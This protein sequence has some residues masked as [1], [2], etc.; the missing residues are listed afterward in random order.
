MANIKYK[1]K[2][3]KW[4]QLTVADLGF[5]GVEN[6]APTLS[7]GSSSTIGTVNDVPL[8]AKLPE[9]SKGMH[10]LYDSGLMSGGISTE[11][12]WLGEASKTCN[13][14]LVFLRDKD[15][16][17]VGKSQILYYPVTSTGQYSYQ[18]LNW[19]LTNNQTW[20]HQITFG[21]IIL[22]RRNDNK[23]VSIKV[24]PAEY[25]LNFQKNSADSPVSS[26]TNSPAATVISQV[27]G[28]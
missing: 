24:S 14:F 15:G 21:D 4:K 26:G 6:K 27:F 3:N 22:Q 25:Y 23:T 11:W 10:T 20:P 28:W 12:V 7:W 5:S 16:S 13:F 19:L 2:E 8:T 1:D 17:F 9:L 18:Y